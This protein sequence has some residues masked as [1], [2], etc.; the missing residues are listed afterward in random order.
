MSTLCLC[1]AS[2]VSE[3]GC[4]ALAAFAC[5][6]AGGAGSP[7]LLPFRLA[8]HDRLTGIT[9]FLKGAVSWYILLT[10][11]PSTTASTPG[12]GLP[13]PA[14]RYHEMEAALPRCCPIKG[15]ILISGCCR[16]SPSGLMWTPTDGWHALLCCPGA[17]PWRRRRCRTASLQWA[18][19]MGTGA[20]TQQSASTRGRA[21]KHQKQ[22]SASASVLAAYRPVIACMTVCLPSAGAQEEIHQHR[23]GRVL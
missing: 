18:A 4:H 17:M 6:H 22:H 3:Q 20:S 10:A 14:R 16:L 23:A 19:L 11:A 7:A 5:L 9:D 8:A 15:L 1:A 21:G 12:R 2:A 13:L